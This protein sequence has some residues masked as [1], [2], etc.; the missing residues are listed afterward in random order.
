MSKNNQKLARVL[1]G[2]SN[3]HIPIGDTQIEVRVLEGKPRAIRV[4][5][6]RQFFPATGLDR[7]IV[8]K[9]SGV[10]KPL[11][12]P[13]EWL[14]PFIS[15][16]LQAALNAPIPF[17][18]IRSI[19]YGYPV[20]LLIDLW[21]AIIEAHENGNTSSR[22]IRIVSHAKTLRSG[23]TKIGLIS[24]VDEITQY[25]TERPPDELQTYLKDLVKDDYHKWVKQFPMEYYQVIARLQNWPIPQDMREVR[26]NMAQITC[27]IIYDRIHTQLLPKLRNLNPKNENGH[28]L[29]KHHQHLTETIGLYSLRN[30]IRHV[31]LL[32]QKSATW[33]D[34]M[35]L[36]EEFYP[37]TYQKKMFNSTGSL[38]RSPDTQQK[39]KN[40]E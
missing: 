30:I 36:L 34:F 24:L 37:K 38:P 35:D 39:R 15:K 19:A 20:E 7:R 1:A 12:S 29:R 26:K 21:D 2:S 27:E 3:T 22:Q 23:I 11:F 6:Q 8:V 10:E 25:Q 32:A 33:G 4:I 31:I 9:S 40:T 17:Q 14:K 28:R 5:I 16:E 13:P 18:G